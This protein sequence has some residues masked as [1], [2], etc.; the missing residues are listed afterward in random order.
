L[1]LFFNKKNRSFVVQARNK[2]KG[3]FQKKRTRA[4]QG[5]GEKGKKGK[6]K[7]SVVKG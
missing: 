4:E 7:K 6:R 5:K 1:S 2:R 3:F